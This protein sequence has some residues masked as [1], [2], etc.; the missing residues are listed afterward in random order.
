VLWC[1]QGSYLGSYLPL[2]K[3]EHFFNFFILG[4]FPQKEKEKRKKSSDFGGFTS[5]GKKEKA[6]KN[7]Q[8]SI[9]SFQCVG[10][11]IERLGKDVYFIFG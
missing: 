8:I 2:S 4:K 3:S 7:R 1:L 10:I 9:F 11:H 6:S 5:L